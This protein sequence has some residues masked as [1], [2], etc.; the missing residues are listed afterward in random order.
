[1][2]PGKLYI[3][4]NSVS[5]KTLAHQEAEL[6]QKEAFQDMAKL[7]KPLQKLRR[8]HKDPQTLKL[9]EEMEKILTP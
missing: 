4:R 3:W 5:H 1:M 2:K 6:L 8:L 7:W 9:I